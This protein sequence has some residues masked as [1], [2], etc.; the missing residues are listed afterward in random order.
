M[1]IGFIYTRWREIQ[2]QTS[3]RPRLPGVSHNKINVGNYVEKLKSLGE[4]RLHPVGE[5]VSSQSGAI[6]VGVL[7]L[8][9]SCKAPGGRGLV[10]VPPPAPITLQ[11]PV[12]EAGA[13]SRWPCLQWLR[14]AGGPTGPGAACTD[15]PAAANP[16]P[17]WSPTATAQTEQQ[18]PPPKPNRPGRCPHLSGGIQTQ[19][20]QCPHGT[21]ESSS[22]MMAEEKRIKSVLRNILTGTHFGVINQRLCPPI[23]SASAVHITGDCQLLSA[24]P[25]SHRGLSI[26]IIIPYEYIFTNIF[27]ASLPPSRSGVLFYRSFSLARKWG[28]HICTPSAEKLQPF[29]HAGQ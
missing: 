28:G 6:K 15:P 17:G 24:R 5:M 1:I 23:C 8:I 9:G 2:F 20:Q 21:A 27:T 16:L 25:P 10:M 7:G 4:K 3:L 19:I 12:T 29:K 13:A 14:A 11:R 18:P 22:V 26:T